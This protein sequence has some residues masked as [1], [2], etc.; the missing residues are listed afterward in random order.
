[1]RQTECNNGG[2]CPLFSRYASSYISRFSRL[3]FR[4]ITSFRSRW[5]RGYPSLLLAAGLSL[6]PSITFADP[7][8]LPDEYFNASDAAL[9]DCGVKRQWYQD[10]YG[11]Q[12]SYSCEWTNE[13]STMA[14]WAV[15]RTVLNG[16]TVPDLY[17]ALY[18][19]TACPGNENFVAPGE[20]TIPPP[21][22]TK[23][24]GC[25]SDAMK[26]KPCN[27]ATGNK[28]HR[29][30]DLTSVDGTIPIIRY[31]NS[32]LTTPATRD[33]AAPAPG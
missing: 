23:N 15:W 5:R 27:A 30:V 8:H 11:Y 19:K 28:F 4:A 12:S 1:M 24:N 20:C 25:S 6:I 18:P 13:S 29:E 14:K 3:T 9:A 22:A 32:Q 16:P 7:P 33:T 10:N 21:E 2:E 26:G 17:K 31:Y